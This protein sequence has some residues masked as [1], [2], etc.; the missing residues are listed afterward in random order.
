MYPPVF[1]ILWNN[2]TR[3]RKRPCVRA[4]LCTS[5]P[6]AANSWQTDVIHH[7]TTFQ[8][9][10]LASIDRSGTYGRSKQST[11]KVVRLSCGRHQAIQHSTVR[12][13]NELAS[14]H[15]PSPIRTVENGCV[16][17]SDHRSRRDAGNVCSS[18]L[19]RIQ[20]LHNIDSKISFRYAHL[21]PMQLH[22]CKNF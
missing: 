15:T 11:V 13:H 1:G 4:E 21:R 7:G 3:I 12:L 6:I 19:L 20:V 2:Q 18:F 16:V 5:L 10:F 9:T 17:I 14:P 8:V 22:I